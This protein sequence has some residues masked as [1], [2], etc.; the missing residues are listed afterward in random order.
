[1]SRYALW[2][3]H[4]CFS[5]SYT[6]Y[7]VFLRAMW[8]RTGCSVGNRCITPWKSW[9]QYRAWCGDSASGL[10]STVTTFGDLE[11]NEMKHRVLGSSLKLYGRQGASAWLYG[12]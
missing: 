3:S 9:S 8:A 6:W 12:G 5:G 4:I 7:S 11:S 10:E 2:C 1:M